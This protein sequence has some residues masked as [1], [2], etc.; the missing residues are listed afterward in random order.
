MPAGIMEELLSI[1]IEE[2]KHELQGHKEFFS[3]FG[4]RLPGEVWEEY[5][6]LARRLENYR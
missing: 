3:K 6:A 1:N 5:E 2:W 4:D